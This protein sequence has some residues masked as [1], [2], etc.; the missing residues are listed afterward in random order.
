MYS[1]REFLLSLVEYSSSSESIATV[2]PFGLIE[3][4]KW[5]DQISRVPEEPVCIDLFK[6]NPVFTSLHLKYPVHVLPLCLVTMSRCLGYLIQLVNS[7]PGTTPSKFFSRRFFLCKIMRQC[8]NVTVLS[9]TESSCAN[10]QGAPQSR[11][12]PP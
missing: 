6:Q 1:S 5:F 9:Y 10:R 11:P 7:L 12:Y 3:E 8:Y 4:Y 2:P